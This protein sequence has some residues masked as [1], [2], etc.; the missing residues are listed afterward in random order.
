[1]KIIMMSKSQTKPETSDEELQK[2]FK[3]LADYKYAFDESF[4]SA[5]TDQKGII[6][7]ANDNFCKISKYSR[8]ELIGQDHRIINSGFHDKKYIRNLWVT[9]ANG[10]IWRGEFKNKAKDGTYYWVDNTII[11]FLN[12][13]GKPYKYLTVRVDITAKKEA[14]EKLYN[15]NR[16]YA[17]ISQI[18]K[19]IVEVKDEH[20]LFRKVCSIAIEF[21]KF[22]M[23]W[24]GMFNGEN[25][26]ITVVAQKG[27]PAR[28]VKLFKNKRLEAGSP[29]LD[30]SG[31]GTYCLCNDIGR[32]QKLENRDHIAAGY[33]IKSYI[34]LPLQRAGN[35]I[36]TFN[37]YSTVPDFFDTDEIE[38][39]LEVAGDISFAL[40]S[41]DKAKRQKAAED[42]IIKNEKLFRALIEKS[43]D[44]Q[45]LTGKNGEI[46]Y[47]SPTVA[48]VIGYSFEDLRKKKGVDFVHPDDIPA[49][50]EKR[51]AMFQAPSQSV[52]FQVRLQHKDGHYLWCEGTITNLL[53]ES[54]INAI[55]ANF[56]D[57]TERVLASEKI[58]ESESRLKEAQAIAHVGHW[59]YDLT[60]NV[61]VWSDELYN[62]FGIAKN[63]V[64]PSR[65]SLLSL[66]HP[67][68]VS[69]VKKSMEEGFK[70]LRNVDIEFRFI[71]RHGRIRYAHFE[72]RIKFD[73]A[74]NPVRRFGIMQDITERVLAA[75]KLSRSESRL[76]EA[77]TIAH[78]GNWEVDLI[79]QTT[80]WSDEL[81]NMLGITKNEVE[82]SYE[83]ALSFVHPDDLN[84]L[85]KSLGDSFKKRE[86]TEIDFRYID[87]G[88][89]IRHGHGESRLKL[90]E[91]GNPVVH[92][93]IIQDITESVLASEKLSNS[94]ARLKEAQAIARVGNWEHDLVTNADVW[95]DELY[96][97][98]DITKNEVEP[99]RELFLS[100]VH[101]DDVN[102]VKRSMEE[103]YKALRGIDIEFRFMDRHGGIRHGHFESRIKF[104][105]KGNPVARFGIIQDITERVL[106]SEK[107]SNSEARLK[108]AQA[109]AH[110]G[111]WEHDL[112]DKASIWSDELYNIFGIANDVE[113][114][115]KLLLSLVHPD[116][117][118]FVK[119]SFAEGD[120]THRDVDIEFRFIDKQGGIRYVYL[121]SRVKFDDGG[122]PVRRVGIMQDITERK[123]FELERISVLND[124]TKRNSELEQFA[125][126]VSHNLRA[127]VANIIGASSV[128]NDPDLSAEDKEALSK[129][130]N[131]SVMRLDDVV[132]DLND[133]LDVKKDI[134]TN[135][136]IVSFAALVDDIKFSLLFLINEHGIEIKCDFSVVSELFTLRSY[137]YS[138]FHN[139]ISNSI[140][141]RR[142]DVNTLIEIKSRLVKN[143]LELIF[144]DNGIG[145][146]LEKNGNNVFGMYKRFHANV[147]GKGIGLFIVKTQV[148]ALGGIIS[149]QSKE[150]EGTEFKIEFEL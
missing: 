97:M 67:D 78:V 58:L 37:L 102:F 7:Y 120:K 133:I 14:E 109:I 25:Q 52:Y 145:I 16:Q 143:K 81:Y 60:K 111:N 56:R 12:E 53:D 126:I 138:I 96:N 92:Y 34:M 26:K 77:Q 29:Q 93:G 6:T 36:G 107:L 149:V 147:E 38:L 55:V 62:M 65:A 46:L 87:K 121:Q 132:K 140:K 13:R 113:P 119:K 125:Y 68:D 142:S 72:S 95:S 118:S 42:I 50:A 73:D 69:F 128:L 3:E 19:C 32:D 112:T 70:A 131:I 105:N 54:G 76:K 74:G 86:G 5:I 43:G 117:V 123:L 41:F 61:G 28:D 94:E 110:V 47:S 90:D 108:E 23:A 24:I 115:R 146:D 51:K 44:M 124:L 144:T 114:S 129:G 21:G 2:L 127:P 135:K 148:E 99:S 39:L 84:F 141:Y 27:I 20:E 98:F 57:I 122:N 103:G 137:L 35:I 33:G 4:I 40:D 89:R 71:D 22:K 1:M 104:D 83:L 48:N 17:F 63:D 31:T 49:Y 66:V 136:E 18:N 100:F 150:N 85:K 64:Q 11:P 45:T 15:I 134:N 30:V 82:P 59:E 9:I 8:E 79:N 10:K 130:I 80:V 75:E 88:G 91:S 101:P 106:A 139:L 116:D